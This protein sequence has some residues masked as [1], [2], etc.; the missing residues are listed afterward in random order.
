MFEAIAKNGKAAWPLAI[1]ISILYVAYR[2]WESV[3]L[4]SNGSQYLMT[5]E[6]ENI[7]G[8]TCAAYDYSGYF[9]GFEKKTDSLRM[10]R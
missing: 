8:Y 10:I 6:P 9:P 7:A 3:C 1:V 4:G 2:G 5:G